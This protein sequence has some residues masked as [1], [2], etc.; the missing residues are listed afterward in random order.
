MSEPPFWLSVIIT[1]TA[2]ALSISPSLNNP[3]E[4]RWHVAIRFKAAVM[5]LIDFA[6][7]TRRLEWQL[8]SLM[9]ILVGH[10]KVASTRIELCPQ[11]THTQTL[12]KS[13]NGRNYDNHWIG[14]ENQR[15]T[16]HIV[17][18]CT[19][20]PNCHLNLLP[21]EWLAPVVS[22][23]AARPNQHCC[24]SIYRLNVGNAF[25]HDKGKH[26]C[27]GSGE[28]DKSVCSTL[29]QNRRSHLV[30]FFILIRP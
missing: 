22:T 20:A 14:S 8:A 25:V 2:V 11:T 18:W 28:N 13:E 26:N 21:S 19:S 1:R 15:N 24:P 27:S 23:Q 12:V 5:A 7:S 9:V 16:H 30:A 10:C 3:D 4:T 6:F 29:N 17:L